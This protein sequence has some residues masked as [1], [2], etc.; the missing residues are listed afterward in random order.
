[1]IGHFY[2]STACLHGEH[3][4]C[5]KLQHDR[6]ECGSP[7]CKYC[8]EVCVCPRCRHRGQPAQLVGRAFH[9]DYRSP[10]V[11]R[12]HILREAGPQAGQVGLCGTPGW[13]TKK[14]GHRVLLDPMPATPPAGF[15][16]CASCVGHFAEL[17]GSL[18][19]FAALLAGGAS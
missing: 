12:L 14:S 11:R 18:A 19:L 16:W 4:A 5:G 9:S 15:C 6:G 13:D 10:R 3:D 1:M 2:L 7:H 17:S 8:P